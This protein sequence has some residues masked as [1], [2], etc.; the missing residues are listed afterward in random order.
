MIV[1]GALSGNFFLDVRYQFLD[2]FVAAGKEDFTG[3]LFDGFGSKLFIYTVAA[4]EKFIFLAKL[5][6]DPVE[7]E[8]VTDSNG[9]GKFAVGGSVVPCD[10]IHMDFFLLVQS[11]VSG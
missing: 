8:A 5:A 4:Q 10:L 1:T 6:G 9:L 3:E 7:L 2:S 11:A